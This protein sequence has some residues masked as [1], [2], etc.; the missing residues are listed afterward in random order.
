MS[1]ALAVA[2]TAACLTLGLQATP[3]SADSVC[4]KEVG[5]AILT[6]YNELGGE[7]GVLGCPTSGELTTPDGR[8]RYNTFDHGSIY[9]TATT[10]AHPVW[11]AIR[12][13][14]GAIGWEAGKLGYPVD[15][16]LTN[17]DGQG[18]RQQF[19]G[20]TVY[21]HPTRSNGAH[22]V[23]GRIG[24]R[25][26]QAQWEAGRYGYPISDE[27]QVPGAKGLSQMFEHGPIAWSPEETPNPQYAQARD[28]YLTPVSSTRDGGRQEA[29]NLLPLGGDRGIVVVRG[30]IATDNNPVNDVIGNHRQWSTDPAAESKVTVAWDTESGRVGVYVEHSCVHAPGTSL[31]G[32]RD[33]KP[34]VRTQHAEVV[35]DDQTP[36]NEY[37]VVPTSGGGIKVSISAVNSFVDVPGYQYGDLG[38]INATFS[39][40]PHAY[41]DNNKAYTGFDV[42]TQKDKFPSWE[43]LRYPRLLDSASA[44]Q[45]KW[46]G[47]VWQTH[48]SDLSAPQHTCSR[49]NPDSSDATLNC[50]G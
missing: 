15:D 25:W 17:P 19:E 49:Y 39:I 41:D 28:L 46:Q 11:G 13:K 33:A 38:R 37:W 29:A 16:E 10:G 20:G 40:S 6:K 30:Y 45:A 5:G 8:G 44:P 48:V 22:P 3:A 32:C 26:G 35:Q 21:W 47:A 43:V 23:W 2:A 4:G 9:W 1:K 34:L 27:V 50:T 18:K 42:W 14:W 24:E 7:G 12:D 36:Q 31:D